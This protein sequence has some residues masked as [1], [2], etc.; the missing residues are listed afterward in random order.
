MVQ[1]T[2][3][4]LGSPAFK[5]EQWGCHVMIWSMQAIMQYRICCMYN[6]SRKIVILVVIAFTAEIL[7]ML[8]IDFLYLRH[9]IMGIEPL[10]GVHMCIS[11][12]TNWYFVS[13]IP[14]FGYELL[15]LI[16]GIRAGILFLKEARMLPSNFGKQSLRSI[17][18]RDSILYPIIAFIVGVS[19]VLG[20][21]KSMRSTT[22]V[23]AVLVQLFSRV[24]GSRLILNLRE[25][26]YLPF[27]EECSLNGRLPTLIFKCR[28]DE[29]V[30]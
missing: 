1:A 15:I 18:L 23:A 16:L 24:L 25:A 21:S 14:I 10:P 2:G 26:Y 9:I 28:D 13:W 29:I 11:Y 17:L 30:I 3:T 7:A 12:P 8:V 5:V 6:Y 27:Q 4:F 19:N 22:L 20:W